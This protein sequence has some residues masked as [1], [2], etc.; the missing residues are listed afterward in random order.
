MPIGD[1]DRSSCAQPSSTSD[2]PTAGASWTNASMPGPRPI[3][4]AVHTRLVRFFSPPRRTTVWM[5]VHV[6]VLLCRLEAFPA[7]RRT[8]PL[9]P[10]RWTA[11]VP[12]CRHTVLAGACVALCRRG[13]ARRFLPVVSFLP[14]AVASSSRSAT[15]NK[16]RMLSGLWAS[17]RAHGVHT[18]TQ[19]G[20]AVGALRRRAPQARH[21]LGRALLVCSLSGFF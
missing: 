1:I 14:L 15:A 3:S 6:I 16:P 21:V 9:P 20:A 12:F 17:R 4:A 11:R 10:A 7:A 13:D 8:V 2:L 5:V 18:G 19:G